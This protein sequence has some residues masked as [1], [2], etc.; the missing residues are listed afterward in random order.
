MTLTLA[1]Q[2]GSGTLVTAGRQIAGIGRFPITRE[3][4]RSLLEQMERAE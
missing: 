1:T 4:Q 3:E 2:A